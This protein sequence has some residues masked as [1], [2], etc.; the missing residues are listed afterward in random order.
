M[1]TRYGGSPARRRALPAAVAVLLGL[2]AAPGPAAAEEVFTSQAAAANATASTWIPAPA[3]PAAVCIV[4]TGVDPNPDTTN[5]IA[6]F[7]V[8]GGDPGDI[9]TIGHH[10]TLM[11]MIASAPYNGW[12]M[13]GAA[14]SVNVVSVRA[15]RPGESG[16][17]FSD[18]LKGMQVC[19]K[20]RLAFNIKVISLSLGGQ[21]R[22]DVGTETLL[23]DA[24]DSARLAGVNVVAA[25]GNHPGPSD[26]PASY[27]PVLA[28]GSSDAVGS[29]CAFSASGADV[30]LFAPGCPQDVALHDGRAAWASGTSESTAF[31]AGALAQLRGLRPELGVDRVEECLRIAAASGGAGLVVDVEASL[32]AAGAGGALAADAAPALNPSSAQPVPTVRPSTPWAADIGAAPEIPVSGTPAPPSTTQQRSDDRRDLAAQLPR[33]VVRTRHLGGGFLQLTF[34]NRPAKTWTRIQAY[35][36]HRRRAFPT[37]DPPRLVK[38]DRMRTRVSGTVSQMSIMYVDPAA[39]QKTSAVLNIRP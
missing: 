36:R 29:R 21:G 16:F 38:S 25:A 22:L 24:I 1:A 15:K 32:R 4:D 8:D 5:V 28:I 10:G 6:R 18:V 30:D 33:P 37:A 12:G 35:S 7:S 9:D 39:K 20:A 34:V 19:S 31:V 23:E 14:P 17:Y 26:W 11:A 27:A 13:V 2:L 3:N